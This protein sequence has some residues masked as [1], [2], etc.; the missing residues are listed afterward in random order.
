MRGI[1]FY[2]SG[3]VGTDIYTVP[4]AYAQ[5]VIDSELFAG[6]VH[7]HFD[8]TGGNAGIAIYTFFLI[9]SDDRRELYGSG[10]TS[11]SKSAFQRL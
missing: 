9:D 3:L 10:H 8:R 1:V 4:A 6:T 11:S 7:A 2:E 5:I